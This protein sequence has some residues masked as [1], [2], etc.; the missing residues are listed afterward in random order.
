V[1]I[2]EEAKMSKNFTAGITVVNL[3]IAIVLLTAF[4]FVAYYKLFA[5]S[6]LV[7]ATEVSQQVG[8]WNKA[9]LAYA[10]ETEKLGSFKDIGFVPTGEATKD[11]EAGRSSTFN[12][13]SDLING[14][15]RFLAINRVSLDDCKKY[16]G[17]W[18]AYINPEQLMGNAVAELPIE[19]CAILTPNFEL[20]REF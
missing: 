4:G 11:G 10:L 7:R 12:Y 14:R 17:Q 16:K 13:S 9:H 18:L 6:S 15:G 19:R 8:K 3:V 1:G 5:I 20:L 2:S